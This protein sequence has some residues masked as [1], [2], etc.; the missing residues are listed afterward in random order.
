[1]EKGGRGEG[2]GKTNQAAD[3]REALWTG[4]G[5]GEGGHDVR[6]GGSSFVDRFNHL[7]QL[8]MHCRIN[9]HSGA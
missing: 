4:G 1:M 2:G 6:W 5:F 7:V 3:V 9:V 8:L